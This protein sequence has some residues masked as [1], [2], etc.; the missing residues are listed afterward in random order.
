M[1]WG[2]KWGDKYWTELSPLKQ[3]TCYASVFST[4]II[5]AVAYTCASITGSIF[6]QANIV[7]VFITRSR[8]IK[9]CSWKYRLRN[10]RNKISLDIYICFFFQWVVHFH[11][12]SKFVFICLQSRASKR[13]ILN[14]VTCSLY[15]GLQ[16]I[17]QKITFNS[18]IKRGD[19]MQE[20]L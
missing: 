16:F 2:L 7:H 6:S 18:F 19:S 4:L 20:V 15:T 13:C 9:A 1:K 8:F 5:T 17:N 14:L 11:K 3:L 12:F 10:V